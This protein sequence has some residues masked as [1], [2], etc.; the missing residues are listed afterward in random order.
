MSDLIG[1]KEAALLLGISQPTL[2]R[3]VASGDVPSANIGAAGKRGRRL[4]S[5]AALLAFI[6]GRLDAG[7]G[8]T[9]NPP[10]LAPKAAV[11]WAAKVTALTRDLDDALTVAEALIRGIEEASD[12]FKRRG[13]SHLSYELPN[14]TQHAS[15]LAQIRA[16]QGH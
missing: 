11:A 16:T 1:S 2:S 10:R 12:K 4:F 13:Y 3:L 9:A 6:A 7:T 14:T 8:K 15:V 5:R